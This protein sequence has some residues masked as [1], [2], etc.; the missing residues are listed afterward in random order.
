MNNRIYLYILVMAG[1]TYLIRV[2]PLTL[3]RKEIKNTYI[4]SF[5]YY[6]PYVTLSVMT[7]P[8]ILTATASVWSAVTALVIAIFLAYKGKSLFIVSL[9]A[10]TAVFLTE[11]FL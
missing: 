3:I 4:R 11:L 8:A 9:A 10:C 7:F 6:V 2:L 5:L 1:V